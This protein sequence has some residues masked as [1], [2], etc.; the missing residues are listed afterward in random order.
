MVRLNSQGHN[1]NKLK[2]KQHLNQ[3]KS[4]IISKKITF[5]VMSKKSKLK[6]KSSISKN[7]TYSR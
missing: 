3:L 6:V 7:I 2:K 4:P 5:Y 1:F